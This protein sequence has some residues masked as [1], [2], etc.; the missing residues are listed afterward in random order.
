MVK[1][2]AEAHS[3]DEALLQRSCDVF[4]LLLAWHSKDIKATTKI[5]VDISHTI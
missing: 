3:S 4:S 2:P 5:L 1:L